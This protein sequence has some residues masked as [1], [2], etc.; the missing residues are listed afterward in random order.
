MIEQLN[1]IINNSSL[2]SEELKLPID[3]RAV[4]AAVRLYME[5]D[6]DEY[7][8]N[9]RLNVDKISIE[10]AEEYSEKLADIL[11]DYRQHTQLSVTRYTDSYSSKDVESTQ[12]KME[13]ISYQAYS[14]NSAQ[15]RQTVE[16]STSF[17]SFSSIR[18][19]QS[20]FSFAS[21]VR[22]PS[23][24]EPV[25]NT[26]VFTHYQQRF[27]YEAGAPYNLVSHF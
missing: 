18:A 1:E 4:I 2:T 21:P 19:H 25:Q 22:K 26:D 14:G 27:H 3:D 13:R 12:N 23:E 20:Q 7:V 9:G 24:I 15:N 10:T 11:N 6:C 17:P 8:E 16:A 5:N